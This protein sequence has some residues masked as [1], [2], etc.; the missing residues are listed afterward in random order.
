MSVHVSVKTDASVG[1]DVSVRTDV[2]ICLATD[3]SV[4]TLHACKC[5]RTCL[6][7]EMYVSVCLLRRICQCPWE[8]M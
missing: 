8:W 5:G 4:W 7:G 1:T 6:R 3:T 2:S